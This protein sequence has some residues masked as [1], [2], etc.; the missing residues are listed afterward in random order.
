MTTLMHMTAGLVVAP[1][2]ASADP[3]LCSQRHGLAGQQAM[4]DTI[5]ASMRMHMSAAAAK[6]WHYT[7]PA[8]NVYLRATCACSYIMCV[9]PA[10]I[11]E[12]WSRQNYVFQPHDDHSFGVHGCGHNMPEQRSFR[13]RS[14][15]AH[16]AIVLSSH[17]L[18][19][20]WSLSA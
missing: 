10:P 19:S 1:C 5:T 13:A 15:G 20:A 11:N 3:A 8:D 14:A 17:A 12:G 9:Q 16:T 4:A 18:L 6:R 7:A 2:A